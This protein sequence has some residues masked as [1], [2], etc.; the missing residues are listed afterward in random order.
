MELQ[1][2]FKQIFTNSNILEIITY[3][4]CSIKEYYNE[5]D[6]LKRNLLIDDENNIIPYSF[7]NY[8]L[9]KHRALKII[10]LKDSIYELVR[11]TN[12]YKDTRKFKKEIFN[13]IKISLPS[14]IPITLLCKRK[15]EYTFHLLYCY[16]NLC[17]LD[18]DES[19]DYFYE[20]NGDEINNEYQYLLKILEDCKR[21]KYF[22]MVL[23]Y[24][25]NELFETDYG[26]YDLFPKNYLK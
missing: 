6:I 14:P 18:F 23:L 8:K 26:F 22:K 25:Y 20:W 19:V 21:R 7:E 24:F 12:N 15:L 5:K 10:K 1:Q 3:Y 2:K 9:L 13:F 4:K 17:I 16:F 11:I